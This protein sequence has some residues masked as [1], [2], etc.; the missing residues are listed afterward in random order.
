MNKLHKKGFTFLEVMVAVGVIAV[1]LPS[2]FAVLYVVLKQEAKVLRLS[3]VKRQGDYALNVME[4]ILRNN[5]AAIYS[6]QALLTERCA[7]PGATDS[8][9]NG[10][11]N[12]YF[13][14]RNSNYLRFYFNANKISSGSA[15]TNGDIT[16]NKV[17][18][19]NFTLTCRRPGV[20]SSSVVGVSFDI[21]YQ[22]TAG[23]CSGRV[24]EQASMHYQTSIKLRNK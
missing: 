21:C 10:S 5:A 18:I 19:Q 11:G 4:V 6:D 14:D 7:A 16:S 12:F 13:K 23:N 2:L 22:N 1:T 3:E 8:I 9:V 20:Y 24:E 15:T 17:M